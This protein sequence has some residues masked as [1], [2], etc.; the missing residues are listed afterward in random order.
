M[1]SKGRRGQTR[2]RRA[3]LEFVA[4]PRVLTSTDS[5]VSPARVRPQ[6]RL[7]FIVKQAITLCNPPHIQTEQSR[8]IPYFST[9]VFLAQK[10]G[11]VQSSAVIY[12]PPT[13]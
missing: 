1:T 7:P 8:V 12:Q 9:G 11:A 10:D 5:C 3:A 6:S 2:L 4:R 13:A